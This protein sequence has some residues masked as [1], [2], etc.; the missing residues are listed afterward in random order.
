MLSTYGGPVKVGVRLRLEGD[1]ET[2]PIVLLHQV[3]SQEDF[4]GKVHKHL[5]S[6]IQ[7]IVFTVREYDI[8]VSHDVLDDDSWEVLQVQLEFM[9]VKMVDAKCS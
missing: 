7:T 8:E 6:N 5:G 9:K 1:G 4:F 2:P 3:Q